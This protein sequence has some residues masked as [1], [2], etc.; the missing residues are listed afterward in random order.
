MSNKQFDHLAWINA[1]RAASN[2]KSG[3]HELRVDI[4]KATVEIVNNGGYQLGSTEIKINNDSIPN[5]T[6]F[7]KAPPKLQ[8]NGNKH[9]TK[10]SCIEADCLETAALLLKAE[11]NPCVLNM[12]SAHNPGGGVR[13]GA[14]AQE[15]NIFRRTNLFRSLYQFVDYAKE[16]GV[17]PSTDRYPLDDKTGGIYSSGIT[18]FKASENSG[19]ALLTEPYRLSFVSVPALNRPELEKKDGTFFIADSFVE[20]AK[21]KIRTILRIAAAHDHKNLVLSAF[22]CGAFANPPNH[23]A[24]LFKQVF[25][26]EEFKNR[27]HLVVFSI[28]DDHNSRKEQNPEGNVLPFLK[29][30]G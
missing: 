16:Y 7:Y 23:V 10:F 25:S 26:E 13:N 15:E 19:Y 1:F 2:A 17:L 27:F 21:E 14:G 12:A 28:I 24:L 5:Q 30:F 20:I 8:G 11:L 18:V 6:E 9:E 22:G 3:F 29:V 4:W